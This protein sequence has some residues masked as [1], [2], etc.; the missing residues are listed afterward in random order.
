MGNL[1]IERTNGSCR[2]TFKSSSVLAHRLSGEMIWLCSDAY[3]LGLYATTK[4]RG[5]SMSGCA[6]E[7]SVCTF[8]IGMPYKSLGLMRQE[9]R[10]FLND[11]LTSRGLSQ[12]MLSGV[13]GYANAFHSC[14]SPVQSSFTICHG[15][16]K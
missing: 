8:S 11:L 2:R 9:H 16:N 3:L 13:V 7:T 6:R 4:P 12:K 5:I 15:P 1:D 10:Q 14:P